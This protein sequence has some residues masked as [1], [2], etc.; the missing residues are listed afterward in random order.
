MYIFVLKDG[1]K[2]MI[3]EM[4]QYL[5]ER[6]PIVAAAI[7]A[8]LTQCESGKKRI[9]EVEAENAAHKDEIKKHKETAADGFV[10][11]LKKD[12]KVS[13]HDEETLKAARE[14]YLE[15]A[16]RTERIYASM[17]PIIPSDDNDENL[18]ANRVQHAEQEYA[19]M[20]IADCYATV[21]F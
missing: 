3:K 14:S 8:L 9:E 15:N 11:R 2:P 17:Q 12:G 5:S 1:T 7:D 13:P 10:E 19:H 18:L 16:E 20:S 4:N 6:D 21:S